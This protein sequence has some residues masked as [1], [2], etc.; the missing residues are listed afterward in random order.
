M[1]DYLEE[2]VRLGMG[3]GQVPVVA[4][5]EHGAS[6]PWLGER[7]AAALRKGWKVQA[8]PAPITEAGGRSAGTALVVPGCV[9][10]R[11]AP[12]QSSWDI[13]PAGGPGRLTMALIDVGKLGWVVC[14]AVY[15]W[16]G[17]SLATIRNA[18][19]LAVMVR[20]LHGLKTAV[21]GCCGLAE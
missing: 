12:G 18:M 5:Q 11:M 16:T 8:S 3:E 13:S 20:W 6:S 1:L 4:V 17:D 2:E 9:G 19:L 10:V 21:D 7:A 15:M 14:C